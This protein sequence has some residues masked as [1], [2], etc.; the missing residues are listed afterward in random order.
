[1]AWEQPLHAFQV[2]SHLPPSPST[3]TCRSEASSVIIRLDSGEHA[4]QNAYKWPF[5]CI[6]WFPKTWIST[7]AGVGSE[8]LLKHE[9]FSHMRRWRRKKALEGRRSAF[10]FLLDQAL[11]DP[12]C[13]N[14]SKMMTFLHSRAFIESLLCLE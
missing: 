1:M 2:A 5:L 3:P 8:D 14:C 12:C 13:S 9:G 7:E 11:T 10:C 4:P 6:Y